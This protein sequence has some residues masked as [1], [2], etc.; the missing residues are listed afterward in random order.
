MDTG[1]AASGLTTHPRAPVKVGRGSGRAVRAQRLQN[2]L[3][4]G[5]SLT[6]PGVALPDAES[7]NGR[8]AQALACLALAVGL[9]GCA[10]YQPA[11]LSPEQGATDLEA[12][13]LAD[14]SLRSFLKTNA[15]APAE[16][17][18]K[19]WDLRRLTLA[20]FYF[21]PSLDVARAQWGV[22]QAGV[23]TAGGRLN[24]MLSAVP[25]YS[26]NAPGGV[27]PWF[28]LVS[29]DVPLETAGKRGYRMAHA[30]Q[31]S[32][33]ARLNI[34]STAWQVRA[35]LRTSLLDYAVARGRAG[36]F[37]RQ[38][39]VQQQ[40]VDL[41]EARLQAGVAARTELTPFQMALVKTSVDGAEAARQAAEAR[42]RIAEAVGL[43]A[44]AVAGV[45][46][47]FDLALPPDA[48]RELTTAEA[49][50]QA[51][52]GRADV[53]AGL[54][55]YAASESAL[56]LE[57]AKQYPDV[58]LNPGYQFDQGEHKWSLGLSLELPVLNQNQGPIA[59]AQAKRM[60]TA[61]RFLALQAKIM[62]EIDR[63]LA[64]RASA[65]EQVERQRLLTQLART[66]SASV[67]ALFRTGAADKLELSSA[68]LET[69][70][71]DLAFL[72]AQS[73]ALQAVGLLEEALQRPLE[74]WPALEQGRTKPGEQP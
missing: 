30:Q 24:P 18:P 4:L 68:Q 31:L 37:Q 58:H 25:G 41:L 50:R 6:L 17:P 71:S 55:E 60:E 32:E 27:S 64:L 49:R 52:L 16:W 1:I 23:K 53:L 56:Q 42:A 44:G 39:A 65:L 11:A 40:I 7:C 54:S 3:R 51:L 35:N 21:H 66:Q 8:L 13:S 28:P 61:A 70:L 38:R 59:E 43:P 69:S 46:F 19:M 20:A 12:R 34:I 62:S 29:L 45:E 26:M 5:W 2:I 63:A 36:L 57:I 9:A 67:E 73:K 48:A 74:G 22:A 10:H 72:D 47:S 33:A 15:A 14:A